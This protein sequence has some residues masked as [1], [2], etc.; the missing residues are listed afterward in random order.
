[1]PGCIEWGIERTR[2]CNAW[3]DQGQEECAEFREACCDWPPCSWFCEVVS[4]FCVAFVWVANVVCVGWTWV[5]TAICVAWDVVTTVVN[6]VLVTV[7]SILGW[8]LS[9]IAFVIEMI[10]AIPVLGALVRWGLNIASH[11]VWIAR[12]IPDAIL[13]L[14][15]IRPEK[16]MRVCTVILRDEAGNPVAS[17]AFAQQQLQLAVNMFKRDANVRI[18]PLGPFKYATGFA[19]APIV[20]ETW[21]STH[22]GNSGP[23]VLDPSCDG[24][25]DFGLAGTGFQWLMSTN[26]FYGAWR[27]LT[28]YG[29]PVAV[30]IVRSIPTDTPG[31]RFLGCSMWITD[32]VTVVGEMTTATGTSTSP[33]TL[34]HELGHSTNLWHLCSDDDVRNLM[35]VPGSCTPRGAPADRTAPRL[36]NWQALLVRTSKH[37]TYF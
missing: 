1:M 25:S 21:F 20:D 26:C 30:F 33:R 7:E 3:E 17:D 2:E 11:I 16:K 19:G 9:A 36:N 15:G 6:A 24:L 31:T 14:I 32:Y 29:A 4:W 34:G 18:E 5:T 13:G 10:Q 27:R 22:R 12:A 8:V 23:D 37:V 35:A 28:G